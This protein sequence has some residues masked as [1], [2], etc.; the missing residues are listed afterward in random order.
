MSVSNEVT[1]TVPVPKKKKP[2]ELYRYI[3]TLPL[4]SVYISMRVF[5]HT[6]YQTST[7]LTWFR[8]TLG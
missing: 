7:L 1:I 8:H 4:P 5:S 6:H 3:L 2:H